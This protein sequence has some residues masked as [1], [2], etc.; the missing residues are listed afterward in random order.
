[1]LDI[2]NGNLLFSP[3][4]GRRVSRSAA[5]IFGD[6]TG[7]DGVDDGGVGLGVADC[8][9]AVVA[10]VLPPSASRGQCQEK[11]RARGRRRR[12]CAL[13]IVMRAS[14]ALLCPALLRPTRACRQ[15]NYPRGET[16]PRASERNVRPH[17]QRCA[18]VLESIIAKS[19]E[20][21]RA[22]FSRREARHLS[23]WQSSSEEGRRKTSLS[24]APSSRTVP[25][26]PSLRQQSIMPPS[27]F[28]SSGA[29]LVGSYSSDARARGLQESATAALASK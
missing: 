18:R 16:C 7:G 5:G 20:R 15:D 8:V 9:G 27:S 6:A 10:N 25:L 26:F 1:L 29:I 4:R 13:F 3:L 14:S 17:L 2:R 28:S 11:A 12:R 19:Y 22:A 23:L 24:R 21:R